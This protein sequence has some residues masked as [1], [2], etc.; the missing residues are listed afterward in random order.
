M[1]R[2]LPFEKFKPLTLREKRKQKL[3]K[4]LYET[5]NN[6]RKKKFRQKRIN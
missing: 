4:I 5:N 1:K 6:S 3:K 2:I